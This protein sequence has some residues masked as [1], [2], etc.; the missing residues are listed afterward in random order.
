MKKKKK[1]KPRITFETCL[2]Q[3]WRKRMRYEQCQG[4]TAWQGDKWLI[5]QRG[6][7][8]MHYSESWVQI[9]GNV[10]WFLITSTDWEDSF[11]LSIESPLMGNLMKSQLSRKSLNTLAWIWNP[12][13]TSWRWEFISTL[14][15]GIL[16]ASRLPSWNQALM[17]LLINMARHCY[18]CVSGF[19]FA[20]VC[21]IASQSEACRPGEVLVSADLG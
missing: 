18:E 15:F 5:C 6:P 7:A 2:K 11:T 19:Y 14:V 16:R 4:H 21:E 9:N 8:W 13:T 12:H 20:P 1:K 3:P 10:I 17:F